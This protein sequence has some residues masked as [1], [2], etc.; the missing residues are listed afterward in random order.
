MKEVVSVLVCWAAV[1]QEVEHVVPDLEG[2]WFDSRLHVGV[3]LGKTLNLHLPPDV[4][5]GCM[6][7]WERVNV[8]N[9]EKCIE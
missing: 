1:A 3:T 6:N 5:I 9:S 4:R 7:V 2:Q 8:T